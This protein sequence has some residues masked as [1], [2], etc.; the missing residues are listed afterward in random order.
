VELI[1]PKVICTLGN[2]AT[3]LLSGSPQGITKVRGQPQVR[4][5]GTRTVTLFPIFHPSA[6]LRTPAVKEQLR[7]DFAK[8]SALLAAPAP[9]GHDDAPPA[10]Q[11]G[12][13]G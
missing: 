6:G 7:E 1:E 8:L 3:K 2:F 13:F 9:E 12:L 10:D 4:T 5:L 11:L